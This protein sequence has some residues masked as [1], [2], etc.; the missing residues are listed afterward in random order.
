MAFRESEAGR[1]AYSVTELLG[2]VNQQYDELVASIHGIERDTPSFSEEVKKQANEFGVAIEKT[3]TLREE[4]DRVAALPESERASRFYNLLN[5]RS[6]TN[7]LF[8]YATVVNGFLAS[9]QTN[10][11]RMQWEQVAAAAES[12]CRSVR[13]FAEGFGCEILEAR[14]MEPLRDGDNLTPDFLGGVV[15]AGAD[16]Y[17]RVMKKY[18]EDHS[19]EENP[20]PIV[21]IVQM[22]VKINGALKNG[23]VRVAFGD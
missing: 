14:I 16:S 9:D 17:Q 11:F 15:Y 5:S 12:T 4:L 3:G 22:P 8:R 18:F 2:R 10:E 23:I 1:E 19:D 6:G 13:T 7:Q 21:E 20:M